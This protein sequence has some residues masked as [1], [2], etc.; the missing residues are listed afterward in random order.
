MTRLHNQGIYETVNG[1]CKESQDLRIAGDAK[2]GEM[3]PKSEG[4][5][6]KRACFQCWEGKWL[7]EEE[8]E[9]L[10]EEL[11][12]KNREIKFLNLQL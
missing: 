10:K 4:R 11:D 9:A 7:W 1:I 3:L 5:G 8:R 12:A 2:L 6:M